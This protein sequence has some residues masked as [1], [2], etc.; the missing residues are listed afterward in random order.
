MEWTGKLGKDWKGWPGHTRAE[1]ENLG[2]V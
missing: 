1:F 2:E